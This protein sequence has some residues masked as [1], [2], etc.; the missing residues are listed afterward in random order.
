M[1]EVL[2]TQNKVALIDD[3]D[4]ALV[5]PYSWHLFKDRNGYEYAR[6]YK[7]GV[8]VRMHRLLARA[9]QGQLVDHKNGNTLDNR[10]ENLRVCTHSE[11][12]RNQKKISGSSK[13]K[14][15]SYR[16]V[17]NKW[18]S[19]IYYCGKKLFLGLFTS[20]IEAAQ[21]YDAKASEL[22]GQFACINFKTK[23]GD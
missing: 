16:K 4:F 19:R 1:K 12:M 7:D 10:Q 17:N 22:Y 13:Y 11:N 21:A 2:L 9:K 6:G 14:G 8:K 3:E 5:A 20:E 15:V 23:G 18:E